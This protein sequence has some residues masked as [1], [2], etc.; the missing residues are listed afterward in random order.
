MTDTTQGGRVGSAGYRERAREGD[1]IRAT[2]QALSEA[3]VKAVMLSLI[4]N[5]GMHRVKCIPL[6]RLADAVTS[7]VGLATLVSVWLVH[8]LFAAT[9]AVDPDEPS[10]DLRLIPDL[11]ACAPLAAQPGWAWCPVDQFDQEGQPWGACSRLFLK[12]MVARLAER[13]VTLRGAFELEWFVGID[14]DPDPIPLNR[15]PAYSAIATTSAPFLLDLVDALTA[16]GIAVQQF[17]PEYSPGQF[18]MSIGPMDALEAA[19]ATVLFRQTIRGVTASHGLVTS[20]SPKVSAQALGNGA[21]LHFSLWN[22]ET[23][24]LL[25]GGSAVLGM[26]EAGES[27]VA[28][29]LDELPALLAV[30]APSV[31]SYL[32][33]KPGVSSG[34]YRAWGRENREAALRFITG[35]VGGRDRSTNVE[36]KPIDLAANPY[37]A[38]GAIIA[39]G[40]EGIEKSLRLPPP[41]T[42]APASL[43]EDERREL[44][45]DRLPE[46]LDEAVSRMEASSVLR[47]AMGDLLFE[48]FLATRRK[49]WEAFGQLDDESMIRAHRWRY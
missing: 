48:T 10:A 20:F 2:A 46:S 22:R 40:L 38:I 14:G 35:M 21:H 25:A 8:D 36:F 31:V 15:G 30:T 39:A 19:D 44:G 9:M 41:T 16:E 3:G 18:E 4:D 33:L 6:E 47:T 29:V 27:F 34:A 13:G 17:H 42:R 45:I 12:G 32:R 49:E 7:G 28:G 24:N 23:V 37:L 26:H 1:E 11:S 5:A 43:T